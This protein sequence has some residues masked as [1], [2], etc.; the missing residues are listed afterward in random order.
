MKWQSTTWLVNCFPPHT[1]Y[2]G[3]D[4]QPIQALYCITSVTTFTLH[5][6]GVKSE[7]GGMVVK[8]CSFL[9]LTPGGGEWSALCSNCFT[10]PLKKDPTTHWIRGWTCPRASRESPGDE[11]ISHTCLP[12]INPG[13][14]F[15]IS[16]IILTELL[17]TSTVLQYHHHHHH[18][19]NHISQLLCA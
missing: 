16:V 19:L 18:W 12:Q 8:Q 13:Y 9:T 7:K 14:T 3:G 2:C 1:C 17:Y 10:P 6:T 5:N 11:K 4:S 15:Q